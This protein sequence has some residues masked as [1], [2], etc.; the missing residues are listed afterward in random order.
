MSQSLIAFY[1]MIIAFLKNGNVE[2]EVIQSL[3]DDPKIT[4]AVM[5]KDNQV[6]YIRKDVYWT[7]HGLPALD[8]AY[9]RG[10]FRLDSRLVY[11]KHFSHKQGDFWSVVLRSSHQSGARTGDLFVFRKGGDHYFWRWDKVGTPAERKEGGRASTG[12]GGV[13]DSRW[14]YYRHSNYDQCIH[15]ND[16]KWPRTICIDNQ[17]R[18]IHYYKNDYTFIIFVREAD[19]P[20]LD[21]SE[22]RDIYNLKPK[23][24]IRAGFVDQMG[25]IYLFNFNG[26][27]WQRKLSDTKA[28]WKS[29]TVT[30]FFGCS[31]SDAP[32]GSGGAQRQHLHD[33]SAH[34][35]AS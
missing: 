29:Q 8:D 22:N 12:I 9:A 3:C 19:A 6:W 18:L 10:P 4:S 27:V 34:C 31:R 30:N 7:G 23:L 16:P 13:W 17:N 15:N 24:P 26:N 1:L 21:R 11:P 2:S 5:L 35:R 20:V 14:P 28:A 32:K 25:F 33:G